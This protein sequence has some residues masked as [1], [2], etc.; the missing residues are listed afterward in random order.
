MD[1]SPIIS[2]VVA[3]AKNGVIGRNGGLP[4]RIPSDLKTFRRTT[5][6]KPL[7]MGRKTYDSIGKPLDGRDNI[8]V[9]RDAAFKPTGVLVARSLE[10]ALGLGQT[11]AANRAVD[12]IMVIGGADIFAALLPEAHRVYWT[13]VDGNVE[14][15]ARFPAFDWS[16]WRIISEEAL[17]RGPKD[18]FACRLVVLERRGPAHDSGLGGPSPPP[19]E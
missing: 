5:M 12:E 4:W 18:E 14:G 2:L 10:E 15:D 6:G 13:R 19:A 9:S 11:C 8:V 7:V 3:V 1:K 17:P 16:D